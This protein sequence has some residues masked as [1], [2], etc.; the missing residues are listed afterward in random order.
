MRAVITGYG[1]VTA[2]GRGT[3]RLWSAMAA[4]EQ[5]IARIARFATEGFIDI[6]GV[7]PDRNDPS[8]QD[9]GEELCIDLAVT[10]IREALGRAQLHEVPASRIALV[11]GTSLGDYDRPMHEV[12]QDIGNAIGARGPRLTVSTACTSSTNALGLALD[13]LEQGNVDVAIAGGADVLSPLVLAGFHR[14]GVLSA[15]PCAPF[16]SPAGTSLGEGAGFLVLQRAGRGRF[17]IHGYGMSSDAYH[18]TGPDPSGLGI[19]RAMTTA[20]AHAGISADTVDYVNAHGT[21]TIAGDAAEWRALK[22]VLGT[23]ADQVPVSSSKSFLGHAQGA[24]G[25]VELI[26]TLV[27]LEHGAIPPTRN[28]V[29]ARPNS[30]PDAVGGD[31]PRPASVRHA[32]CN[33][34]GFGGANCAVVVGPATEIDEIEAG[35]AR[36]PRAVYLTGLGAT[37]AMAS[38]FAAPG[39]LDR[40]VDPRG[41]DAMTTFLVTAAAHALSDA[42]LKLRGIMAERSGLVI[43][44]TRVSKESA[45]TLRRTIDER[46][47]RQLSAPMFSRMVLNA[48]VGACAKQL[49]LRGPLTTITTGDTSGLA[50]IAC[51]AHLLA[52]RDDADRIV[53][54]G[55]E[56]DRRDPDPRT[57]EGAVALVLATEPPRT[58]RIRLAGWAIAG[59]DDVVV[60]AR[61]ALAQSGLEGIDL[62]VGPPEPRLAVARW[63]RP[64]QRAGSAAA[65]LACGVALAALRRGDART[66]IVLGEPGDSISCALVLVREGDPD[67]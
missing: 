53:A 22:H 20:L 18:E 8:W 56:E 7:V 24:A 15:Q 5:G 23:R 17:A 30:P 12:T 1:A 9:R 4:G 14:L 6:A 41:L 26:A 57:L 58:C 60:A 54:G 32:L 38:A 33:S 13:L 21:G 34:S 43:G 35:P 19:A 59:P 45:D 65:A 63:T 40:R 44:T 36:A 10:A 64:E 48:P 37:G 61:A 25:V 50:A 16:S 46:G 11:V 39:P 31:H 27:S 2:Y 28:F 55:V 66:A 52:R 42:G 47:L 62:G 49:G 3:E 67:V 29:G 51:A